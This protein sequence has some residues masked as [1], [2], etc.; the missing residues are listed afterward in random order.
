[1][2][3]QA[4]AD[5]MGVSSSMASRVRNGKRLP[6]TTVLNRL[7]ENLAIPLDDLMAAH[8]AGPVRFGQLVT[9]YAGRA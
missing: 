4:L 2:N 7:H 6:G 9:Q 1:M 8:K 5:Q 3:N